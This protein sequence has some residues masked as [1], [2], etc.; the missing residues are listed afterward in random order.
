[1]TLSV[2]LTCCNSRTLDYIIPTTCVGEENSDAVRLQSFNADPAQAPMSEFYKNIQITNVT[3]IEVVIQ[4]FLAPADA[5]AQQAQ[6]RPTKP[7]QSTST[8]SRPAKPQKASSS[9]QSAAIRAR[10]APIERSS[11]PGSSFPGR[12]TARRSR[13]SKSYARLEAI[14]QV[15]CSWRLSPHTTVRWRPI[16]RSHNGRSVSVS[17]TSTRLSFIGCARRSVSTSSTSQNMHT[18]AHAINLSDPEIL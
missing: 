3:S 1:M 4:K 7:S 16:S 6:E 9:G 15:G 10:I 2:Q 8:T 18:K 12:A 11:H 14:Y 5:K 13:C 17:S